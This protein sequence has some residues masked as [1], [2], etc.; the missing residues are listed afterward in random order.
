MSLSDN[1]KALIVAVLFIAACSVE[2]ILMGYG[3]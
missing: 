1:Q 3:L 2:S